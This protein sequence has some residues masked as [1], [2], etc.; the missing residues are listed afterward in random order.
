M[1]TLPANN[2]S[3]THH[4]RQIK[5]LKKHKVLE[6]ASKGKSFTLHNVPRTRS[7]MLDMQG[8]NFQ[9]TSPKIATTSKIGQTTANLQNISAKVTT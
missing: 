2:Y 9:S 5:Q 4:Q 3:Q 7:Y 6:T 8:N 1:E